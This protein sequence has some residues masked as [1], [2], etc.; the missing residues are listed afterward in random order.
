MNIWDPLNW[1]IIKALNLRIQCIISEK[2]FGAS[3]I[4][5][6]GNDLTRKFMDMIYNKLMKSIMHF[7]N[8]LCNLYDG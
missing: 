8:L 3:L 2:Y 6:K 7:I 1:R 4:D 5:I